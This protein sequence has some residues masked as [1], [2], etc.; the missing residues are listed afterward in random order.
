MNNQFNLDEGRTYEYVVHGSVL[1][2][3]GFVLLPIHWTWTLLFFSVGVGLFFV[4]TGLAISYESNSIRKYTNFLGLKLGK[5]HDLSRYS[6][7]ELRYNSQRIGDK[8][9]YWSS[10]FSPKPRSTDTYDLI[11]IEEDGKSIRINPFLKL[12]EGTATLEALKKIKG[13]GIRNF[14]AERLANK[15]G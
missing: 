7:V 5:W 10:Y 13:L 8:K 4:K 6:A 1:V 15:K 9:V 14:A 12:S 3:S 11:L 2:I